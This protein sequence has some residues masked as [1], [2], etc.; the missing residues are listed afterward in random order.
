MRRV[1]ALLV[2]L[3]LAACGVPRDA[4]PRALED[5]D[6]PFGLPRP[7]AVADPVGPGR[8]PLYFVRGGKVVLSTRP[9]QASTPPTELLRLLF[10]GT[11][12]EERDAGLISVIPANLTVASVELEGRIAVVTLD[13]PDQEVLQAQALAYAQV[14]ATLTAGRRADGVRF[15]RDGADLPVLTGDASLTDR[16]VDR[17]DY[18]DLIATP[19]PQ[20]SSAPA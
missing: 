7:S 5:G 2:L 4:A 17:S 6:L 18:A 9:V 19:A 15:R 13:G 1:L 12:A 20:T 3:A 14:V 8:V 10:E 16:P 11:S